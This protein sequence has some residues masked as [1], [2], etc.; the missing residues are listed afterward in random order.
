MQ[1]RRLIQP[2][3]GNAFHPITG[4]SGLPKLG[5]DRPQAVM[6]HRLVAEQAARQ[7][8]QVAFRE[9]AIQLIARGCR[10][11][12]RRQ[13]DFGHASRQFTRRHIGHSRAKSHFDD[14]WRTASVSLRGQIPMPGCRLRYRVNQQQSAKLLDLGVRQIGGKKVNTHLPAIGY[15]VNA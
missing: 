2:G 9:V 15:T 7:L 5:M 8:A 3:Q 10:H 6:L 4:G 13:P 11:F 1:E 14:R 12:T